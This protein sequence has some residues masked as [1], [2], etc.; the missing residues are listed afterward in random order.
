M[1][2][3]LSPG[4]YPTE[5]DFSAY[6]KALS[7]STF[8]IAGVFE[9]G[10]VG[11]A[12]LVTSLEDARR[13]LGG[14]LDADGHFGLHALK[15]FFENGGSRA[16]VVRVTHLDGDGNSTAVASSVSI[17]DRDGDG[18]ST[19]NPTLKVEANTP[20]L[21][22]D[23]LT[24]EVTDSAAYPSTGFNLIV[25]KDDGTVLETFRDLLMDPTSVDYVERKV[26]GV[27][28]YIVVTDLNSPD[29]MDARPEVG[30]HALTGGD[31]G[32]TG[33]VAADY[34]RALAHFDPVDVN[35]IAVPG[36]TDVTILEGL[37][38][39]VEGRK[40]CIAILEVPPDEDVSGMVDFRKGTGSYTHSA[41]NS[42]YAALYGPWVVA[43]HPVTGR[44]IT[45]PP[46]G[47]VAGIYARN[48]AEGNVWTA[49]AGL[50]RGTLRGAKRPAIAISKGDMDI[51]YPEGIN[52][53]AQV[54]GAFV[55][56]GQ[57]TLQLKASATD[58]VNIR[59]LLVYVEKAVSDAA[60][61]LVFEPNNKATWE[62]FKRLVNPFL[63]RIKDGGGFYDFLTVCD[64]T[65]NTPAVIDANEMRARVM[66]KPTKT[67]EFINI[68]FAIAPTGADFSEL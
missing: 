1:P 8:G 49:P 57:R 21:W 22:G 63:Q 24:V 54:A 61:F 11:E 12:I 50:N 47:F 44:E 56:N 46:A 64:E 42:S 67:A 60:Q 66:V 4:V 31:D 17:N 68:E 14:Y 7:T 3:M 30:D 51:L 5:V 19:A 38:T 32:L 65:I 52:P 45:L 34:V 41:F 18:D 55:V 39:Y 58:R 28:E 35:F 29:N 62:A 48:D 36:E 13:K 23:D 2:E 9:K 6:V 33:L 40:D 59:R 37:V 15:N 26:N 27:S 16:R 20:G 25:K 43:D 53:L 10:P